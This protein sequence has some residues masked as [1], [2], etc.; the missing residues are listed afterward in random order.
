[1]HGGSSSVTPRGTPSRR[2]RSPRVASDSPQA[3]S[4]HTQSNEYTTKPTT[5]VFSSLSISVE[6]AIPI[7][8]DQ[9]SES[10]PVTNGASQPPESKRAPRK[11]KTDALAALNSHARSSSESP[12]SDSISDNYHSPQ[13]ISVSTKLDMS[14]VKTS[15]PKKPQERT[16]ARPFGLEDCPTFYPTAEEFRDPMS[17]INS[18]SATAK[19][20]GICK[21][22]PPQEW[23][24]PFVT[25]TEKF[26]FKTRLQRL[27]AIEA[28]ER[29][30]LNFLEQ[31]YKFHKQQGNPRIVVPR[32]SQKTLDLW[33]LR[34]EVNKLGGYESVTRARK[35]TEIGTTLGYRGVPGISTQLKNSY[36]RVIKPYEEFCERAKN[37]PNIS[38]TIP[39]KFNGDTTSTNG[40]T[41]SPPSSP[42]TNT[43]SPLSEPPD[44]SE[45]RDSKNKAS[46]NRP[47]R[48]TRV[49]S[50]G[51]KTPSKRDKTPS[52]KPASTIKQPPASPAIP[53]P[54]FYERPPPAK[55]SEQHCEICLKTNR[56]EE[57]LLCDGCDYGFHMFCLDPPLDSI[58]KEQWFCYTCLSGTGGDFGFDEG[59]EHSLS[60]FQARDR[61][62]RRYWFES[63]PPKRHSEE[64]EDDPTANRFGN[65]LVTEADVEKEFWRLVQ[66]PNE[67]VEIEYGA[68]VHSTT[69]GSAMPTMETHPLNPYSKDPWNLN[70]MPILGESLLRY[71]KSDISGM[72]VPWIYVGM[73]FSTF[74]WHNEDHYTY[75]INFMHWGETKTWYGIPGADAE[76]FEA[77]IKCEAPDLFEAQP[78]L[79]FQLVTLMNPKRV[80]DA[81][82]RVYSCNQRA[83]EF[84]ITFPKAYH[85]GFN[86]GLNFN[87]AVNFALPDWLPLGRECVSRYREHR[88]L[89][90][91]SHD[92]LLITITEQSST[93][94][95]AMWLIDS[96]REMNERERRARQRARDNGYKE[97]LEKIDRPED[98]YQ[99]TICKAFCYLSQITCACTTKVSCI[100]HATYLC[101]H[102]SH[103]PTLRKRF[104]DEELAET[105]RQI[106]ARAGSPSAWQ[107]KHK[108]ILLARRPA[109]KQLRALLAEGDRINYTLPQLHVLRKCVTRANEWVEA[110]N[111]FIMRRQARKRGTRKSRG[112][113]PLNDSQNLFN[114]DG[115]DDDKPDRGLEELY[116]LLT[117]VETLGFDCPEIASLNS[118]KD[119]ALE[120]QRQAEVL[121][122][123]AETAQDREELIRKCEKLLIEGS[124]LNFV[125]DGLTEVEKIVNRE[126]LVIELRE[127]FA[128]GARPLTLEEVHELIARARSCNLGAENEHMKQLLNR[129]RA[130]DSFEDNAKA[131]L[132][133]PIKTIEQ[134]AE[135]VDTL[136]DSVPINPSI[137]DRI[138]S[139]YAKALDY[140]KQAMVWMSPD[141]GAPKPRVQDVMRLVARA[142]KEFNIRAITDLKRTAEIA[143]DLEARCDQV[144]RGRY[145]ARVKEEAG[146]R[147]TGDAS[148]EGE[149][150]FDA[151]GQWQT[152]ARDH[153]SMFALPIF[154]KLDSQ[155]RMHQSW[156]R[157]LPWFCK[158]HAKPHSIPIMDDVLASTRP[159][160]DLPPTDEYFTCICTTPVRPPPP[161]IVSD[162]VQCDHCHA[163]FHGVCAKNGG[164]CPFCDQTHWNGTLHKDR[165]WHFCFLPGLLSKAPEITKNY[166]LDWKQLE[167]LVHRIDRLSALIGQFLAFTSHPANQRPEYIPQVR[168]Y[169]RKLYKIQF[170]VSPTPDISFGLD[171]AGLHRILAARPLQARTKKRRRPKFTFGQ[172]VDKDWDDGTRCICR[173]RT[174]YLRNYPRVECELCAKFYHA[175][176]VFFPYAPSR[177]D[178]KFVC[179]LCCLRKNRPY[180]Y[181]EVRVKPSE[182]AA[183]E[184]DTYVNIKEMLDTFSKDII[185]RKMPPPYVQ[186]L[187]VELVR[188]VPGQPEITVP[189]TSLGAHCAPGP[190][191]ASSH[192][193]GMPNK[194]MSHGHTADD[195]LIPPRL[196]MPSPSSYGPSSTLHAPPTPPWSRWGTVSTPTEPPATQRRQHTETPRGTPQPPP[197][198]KRKL[199]DDPRPSEDPI[200]SATPSKRRPPLDSPPLGAYHHQVHTP[201]PM[202]RPTQTLSPSLAMIVSPV[203]TPPLPYPSS[204]PSG[205]ASDRGAYNK[206]PGG[207]GIT[208]LRRSN[209][210]HPYDPNMLSRS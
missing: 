57:M 66:S 98:Q 172:D 171:L 118:V 105:E 80:K 60:S 167:I 169:M 137:H 194:S 86:H 195:T 4:S 48:S 153:L 102:G 5:T 9:I 184:A 200:G 43:S 73:A 30:K 154:E 54:A 187:F 208:L 17:Y 181:S 152:Y 145:Q 117:E 90:V 11:S 175:G 29:A 36:M 70:N 134:L 91:F 111:A 37:Q 130:G 42:L 85:A 135:F 97:I 15:G 61:E 176:C 101:E 83:G 126:Q 56:G 20:Y 2:G 46:Q 142:E 7:N 34:K 183:H 173:G 6:G 131:I 40:A 203:E 55:D 1:M 179:P 148:A 191:P 107:A 124:S 127:R 121:L 59:E 81:D 74:C 132:S 25:D 110:A 108:N 16:S 122:D 99:C 103:P 170:A 41:A 18:I 115:M 116:G 201:P 13:P 39:S 146:H 138:K 10:A 205:S 125:V 112:R 38:P 71:I 197:S 87:E 72:T 33:L 47:R 178:N 128:R 113:P 14:T 192:Y 202:P 160:D 129:Q 78:D 52:S 69:H 31:L 63:H 88:K 114:G 35:W 206:R 157:E 89:P 141:T 77:A 23:E 27:N 67:T 19:E 139:V 190:A 106:A 45:M 209:G 96:L 189:S 166:S 164:S 186:T 3:A 133:M 44:D 210:A 58:P 199:P 162:A 84:V 100:D 168:H 109:L 180:Q 136:D 53:P 155:L 93:I 147:A 68:D 32:I 79:L 51:P 28:S 163:R 151:I 8:S 64:D 182:D 75:S 76:K 119:K 150:V 196:P 95:T 161:G 65:V 49:E 193:H 24:M 82:V 204:S 62:F 156:M 12:E 104:S 165:S 144:L 120:L 50:Q 158:E 140:Q 123:V 207:S 198:R 174:S 149:D 159:D 143:Q 188:F 92:E 26:R 185:Y 21:I 94:K 22:V 177:P